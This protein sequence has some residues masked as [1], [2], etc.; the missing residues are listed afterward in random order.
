MR[1]LRLS[2]VLAGL[3]A[4]HGFTNVP[5]AKA[6]NVDYVNGGACQLS[7]PTTDT[8]V[9]PKAT[10]LRNESTT[11]SSFV[12]C[13]IQRNIPSSSSSDPNYVSVWANLYSLD[14]VSHDI[15]CTAVVGI[16][17]GD[18]SSD[19]KYSTKTESIS[20]TTGSQAIFWTNSDFGGIY[21]DPITRSFNISI[22]CKLPPQSAISMIHGNT[23]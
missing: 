10:G 7:I 3:V 15:S 8:G 23:L 6:G 18:A 12:I 13:T 14:G 9:R 20:N 1:H 17:A 22:T 5:E 4:I 21:G 16:L 11:T 19:L 2:T